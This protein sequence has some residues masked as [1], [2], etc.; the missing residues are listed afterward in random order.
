MLRSLLTSHNHYAN[1]VCIHLQSILCL[2]VFFLSCAFVGLD[3]STD[4]RYSNTLQWFTQW[5]TYVACMGRVDHSSIIYFL[6]FLV[7]LLVFRFLDLVQGLFPL[8]D[9]GTFWRGCLELVLSWSCQSYPQWDTIWWSV[10]FCWPGRSQ[11]GNKYWCALSSYL[12]ML[13]CSFQEGWHSCWLDRPYF[14]SLCSPVLRGKI[15]SSI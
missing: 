12:R 10:P 4:L 11:N 5:V 7:S 14:P 6:A 8:S 2:L 9:H 3:G 1:T 13:F 15:G